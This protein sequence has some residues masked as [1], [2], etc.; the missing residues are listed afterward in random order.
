MQL[1][2]SFV[3]G[4][5]VDIIFVVFNFPV[6]TII[7]K[8]ICLFLGVVGIALGSY[9]CVRMNL[10][11]DPANG[12]TNEVAKKL[13]S[14]F[15]KVKIGFDISCVVVSVIVS[16][17][18]LKRIFGVGIGTLIYAILIGKA[19][20]LFGNLLNKHIEEY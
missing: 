13:N 19:I 2:F 9:L 1:P 5:L 16:F 10:I 15:G 6:D 3:F 17:I 12:A 7:K 8:W 11:M 18:V 4:K 14:E 20:S